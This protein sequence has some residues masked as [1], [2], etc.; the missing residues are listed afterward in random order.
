M[1]DLDH[2]SCFLENEINVA[3]RQYLPDKRA[4]VMIVGFNAA[5]VRWLHYVKNRKK[6]QHLTSYHGTLD[7]TWDFS[8]LYIV[9]RTNQVQMFFGGIFR[10]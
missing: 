10:Y 5:D 9:F 6:I 3:V 7:D 2:T 4:N 8:T 1:K